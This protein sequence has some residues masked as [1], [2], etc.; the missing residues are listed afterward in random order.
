M[1]ALRGWCA[2]AWTVVSL[3]VSCAHMLVAALERIVLQSE[4]VDCR[5]GGGVMMLD[6]RKAD[7]QVWSSTV[8]ARRPLA[9]DELKQMR[10]FRL[11]TVVVGPAI[12][13]HG[14]LLEK[15]N[16]F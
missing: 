11:D 10:P 14:S 8:H 12:S 2:A 6:G 9:A 7:C 16:D 3:K 4:F 5:L 1:H 13:S 15:A